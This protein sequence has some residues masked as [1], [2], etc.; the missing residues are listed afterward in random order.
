MKI[1]IL[2]ISFLSSLQ[3]QA[4]T[5]HQWSDSS[6]VCGATLEA[7]VG[8]AANGDTIMIKSNETLTTDLNLLGSGKAVSLIATEGYDPILA[9]PYGILMEVT[10]DIRIEGLQIQSSHIE[11]INND[12]TTTT[13]IS[14]AKNILRGADASV[15]ININN[16]AANNTLYVEVIENIVSG[17]LDKGVQIS[18]SEDS[19]TNHMNIAIIGNQLISSNDLSSGL[20]IVGKNTGQVTANVIGN[21]I[22]GSSYAGINIRNEDAVT[23]MDVDISSN[24]MLPANNGAIAGGGV[25]IDS[26]VNQQNSSV[27]GIFN[28]TMIHGERGVV[29]NTEFANNTVTFN[30]VNNLLAFNEIGVAINNREGTVLN[31]NAKN[32]FQGNGPS[33]NYVENGG[34]NVVVPSDI[35]V[36][37]NRGRLVSESA[38]IDAADSV[39]FDPFI[40]ADG[41][42]RSKLG[43]IDIGAYE[44][45]DVTENHTALTDY[46][47]SQ[48]DI[49]AINDQPD[50]DN[51]HI[52]SAI[53][54][55]ISSSRYNYANESVW[56]SVSAG[57]WNIHNQGFED[58]ASLVRFNVMVIGD[59]TNT[60]QH[61]AVDS[62]FSFSVMNQA[63]LN[64]Q[65]DKVLQVTPHWKGTYNPHPTGVFYSSFTGKWSIYNLDSA[66]MPA[67]TNFN[68]HYQDAS[69]SAWKH[70]ATENNTAFSYTLLDNPLINGKGC[71]QLQVTQS[72]ENEVFNDQPIGVSYDGN[73]EKW[74]IQN[75]SDL[76]FYENMPLGAMFHVLINPAQVE[77]CD[78]QI[79]S[80]SF[81]PV[82]VVIET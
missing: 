40:D 26:F 16:A 28:N 29:I 31:E 64:N 30:L 74:K 3:S 27:I 51:I 41:L 2:L 42:Y 5:I 13:K 44:Y 37:D 78:D 68:V 10:T 69:K 7:C 33:S 67:L 20:V 79:F 62:P 54:L 57:K 75:Q 70:T 19:T 53:N 38:A 63:S 15:A 46:F 55:N 12:P 76:G 59:S 77:T 58:M 24:A 22:Y 17:F 23:T 50:L 36:V 25:I 4:A 47:S 48:L 66:A 14:V 43:G 71:A 11:L 52:T 73:L 56:Y 1:F 61:S 35:N 39:T 9:P 32:L 80:D 21:E 81:E 45:G 34:S 6:S 49:E 60:F 82:S 72:L 18:S 65:P 8:N